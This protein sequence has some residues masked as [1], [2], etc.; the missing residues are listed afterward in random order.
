MPDD[1]MNRDKTGKMGGGLTLHYKHSATFLGDDIIGSSP[2]CLAMIL[3]R[4]VTVLEA[5]VDM[6]RIGGLLIARCPKWIM[7]DRMQLLCLLILNFCID[8]PFGFSIYQD[9]RLR[10]IEL[11]CLTEYFLTVPAFIGSASLSPSIV[12]KVL[13]HEPSWLGVH[14]PLESSWKCS[15]FSGTKSSS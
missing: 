2:Q 9:N 4:S 14:L 3:F 5:N 13:A 10:L 7:S 1:S 11:L 12:V 8:R 15:T 6:L